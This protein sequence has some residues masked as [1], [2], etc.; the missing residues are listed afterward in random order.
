MKVVACSTMGLCLY[1]EIQE[2][3]MAMREKEFTD[4]FKVTAACTLRMGKY[5]SRKESEDSIDNNNQTIQNAYTG[6]SWFRL[7]ELCAQYALTLSCNFVGVIKNGHQ[8]YPKVSW[9]IL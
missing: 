1:L 3:K 5:T 7:V 6:D 8:C 9:K 4:H 2:G